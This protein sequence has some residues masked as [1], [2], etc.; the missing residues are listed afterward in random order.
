M[1]DIKQVLNGVRQQ[2]EPVHA[3]IADQ[4]LKKIIFSGLIT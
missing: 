4:Y 3:G 1:C 2:K